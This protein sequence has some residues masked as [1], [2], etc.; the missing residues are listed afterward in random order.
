VTS[1]V[2]QG[3]HI[4]NA[5]RCFVT[6]SSH[7]SFPSSARIESAAQVKA[8]VFEAMPKRVSASTGAS[9]PARRTP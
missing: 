2:T 4:W 5:G 8:F 6:G 7:D 1:R 3:S 9:S